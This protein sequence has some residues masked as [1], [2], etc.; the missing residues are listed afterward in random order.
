VW[1]LPSAVL[2]K[3]YL[4]G[5]I[6][7]GGTPI[8]LPPVGSWEPRH[9]AN[10][11]GLVIA[12]GADLDPSCYG[13]SREPATG[14]ARPDRDESEWTLVSLA[15]K[16]GIPLLGVCR[17]MQLLNAVL[18]GTL[19]QHLP[20]QVGNSDHLPAPGNFGRVAV[21]VAEGSALAGILGERLDVHCHHHQAIDR[22]GDGLVP[23]ALARDGTVEAVELPGEIFCLGVQWHPEADVDRRLFA[24]LVGEARR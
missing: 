20:D 19:H 22:L 10:L 13:V 12:G 14:P 24:A 5:V 1:D 15:F 7:A 6:A 17:G 9:L 21:E 11:D 16:L 3:G 4:D 2:P 18:G 8:L 23:V